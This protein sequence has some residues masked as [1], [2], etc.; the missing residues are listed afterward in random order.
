MP[1]RLPS[2]LRDESQQV[3][4]D[5]VLLIAP[6]CDGVLVSLLKAVQE[7]ETSPIRSLNLDWRLAEIF[8]DKRTTDVWLQQHAIATIPTRTIDDTAADLLR[9]EHDGQLLVRG[10]R[11]CGR[12][13]GDGGDEWA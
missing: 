2:I 3:A 11:S 13:L 5:A 8:A 9:G 12:D 4:F 10:L 7:S 6:E 1:D